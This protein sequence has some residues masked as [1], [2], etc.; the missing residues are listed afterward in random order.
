MGTSVTMAL[1]T[2][3]CNAETQ[4][5]GSNPYLWPAMVWIDKDTIQVGEIGIAESSDRDILARGMKPGDTVSIDSGA[6][7]IQ[8][9]FEGTV[10]DYVF[11]LTIGMFQ[12]NS[13]PA[14][15]ATAGYRAFQ[16]ALESGI[17][18]HLLQLNSGDQTQIDQAQKEISDA[19]TSAVT[20]AIKG[21]LTTTEELE[22][23]L[24]ILTLDGTI[25][26]GT[27]TF[28]DPTNSIFSVTIGDPL[29]GRLFFYRDTTQNGT[30]DVNTPGVI[31]QGGWEQF[32]FLFSGFNNVIY[33][34]NPQGQL[35]HY[36][37]TTQNGTGDVDTPTVIGLGGW[38]QF[39][40]LFS[41]GNNI[42]YA[43]DQ[44]GRLL[45]YRDMTVNGIGDVNTPS[46]IGLGGWQ[47]F[48]FLFGGGNGVIYA[49]NRQGQLLRY[50]DT[51]QNGTGDVN[52]PQVIGASDWDQFLFLFSGGNNIIYAVDQQGRLLFY[53]DET[54]TGGGVNGPSVIGLGGWEQFGFLFGAGNGIIY[55]A[56]K[57]LNPAHNYVITGTL[58]LAAAPCWDQQIAVN[59]AKEALNSIQTEINNLEAELAR[60]PA[61]QKKAIQLAIQEVE[62]QLPAAQTKLTAA[63]AAL[64]DCQ[65][66][67]PSV[68]ET[69]THAVAA[70]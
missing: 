45:F 55:A 65:N 34:V 50:V 63:E 20:A 19:V 18:S 53:R 1:N 7:T 14:D 32:K 62:K 69:P 22:I 27:A 16:S 42:I 26:S 70:N 38:E 33:A 15:V 60:A 6:G 12:G 35:L 36:V 46:V 25:G 13:T 44:Q 43:V 41:G 54:Q 56:E 57:A 51:T 5:G 29:G 66:A 28:S 47:Q 31:G 9:T 37:D 4:S 39:L 10:T 11:I 48:K 2:L 67:H 68:A 58:T 61:Q 30:G 23:F 3:H 40:F 59:Q 24:H 8:I 17:Q 21:A 52:T 64:K 49:V